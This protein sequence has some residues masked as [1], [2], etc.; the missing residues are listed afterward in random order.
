MKKK[1]RFIASSLVLI[2]LITLMFTS[3]IFAEEGVGRIS[4][5]E[6]VSI[7]AVSAEYP[8]Y[9]MFVVVKYYPT[10]KYPS[11]ESVP[12]KV[13]IGQTVGDIYYSGYVY[14][15]SIRSVTIEGVRYWEATFSGTMIKPV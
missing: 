5:A 8:V 11:K 1:Q 12:M 6:A 15:T 9:K 3:P 2:I 14:R 10:N 4:H 7:E 13:L